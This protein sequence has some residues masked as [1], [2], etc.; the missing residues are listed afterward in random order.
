MYDVAIKEEGYFE[1]ESASYKHFWVFF[2]YDRNPRQA[3]SSPSHC[4]PTTNEKVISSYAEVPYPRTC[5]KDLGGRKQGGG[6]Y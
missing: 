3:R 4:H 5:G 6:P 2:D 1:S